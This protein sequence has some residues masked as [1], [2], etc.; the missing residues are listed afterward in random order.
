MTAEVFSLLGS[1]DRQPGQEH[2]RH[3]VGL[4]SAKPRRRPFVDHRA[5]RQR[6]RVVGDHLLFS[7]EDVRGRG[8]PRPRRSGPLSQPPIE[9]GRTR[10]QLI[11]AMDV[12]EQLGRTERLGTHPGR[13]GL[14]F[15]E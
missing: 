10:V 9:F 3:G 7:S 14:G 6:R 15:V 2:N 13:I 11:E 4:T 1:V 5:H 12:G 8:T